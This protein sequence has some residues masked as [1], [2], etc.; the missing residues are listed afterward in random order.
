MLVWATDRN[1]T[2]SDAVKVSE[3]AKSW[4]CSVLPLTV[5][6]T[7][8][9]PPRRPTPT[10][11][12]SSSTSD[13]ELPPAYRQH[14]AVAAGS[15]IHLEGRLDAPSVLSSSEYGT[16]KT[17]S[18]PP[19]ASGKL[20]SS[21]NHG[22][23]IAALQ[24]ESISDR[25]FRS[26]SLL[27]QILFIVKQGRHCWRRAPFSLPVQQQLRSPVLCAVSLFVCIFVSHARI[28][29]DFWRQQCQLTPDPLSTDSG[30]CYFGKN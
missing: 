30:R 15:G 22:G 27:V 5:T 14:L 13:C 19:R 20:S 23:G 11:P 4:L 16:H 8:G 1:K 10:D 2:I 6:L 3:Q 29:F 26:D 25:R 24:M 12:H 21:R 9:R 17:A 7:L 28:G 18:S